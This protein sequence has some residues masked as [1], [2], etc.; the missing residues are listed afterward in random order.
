MWRMDWPPLFPLTVMMEMVAMLTSNGHALWKCLPLLDPAGQSGEN[1]HAATHLRPNW[2]RKSEWSACW[3]WLFSCSFSAGCRCTV[4]TPGGLSM[5]SLPNK[6]CLGHPLLLSICCATPLPVSTQLFTASWTHAS[7]KLCLPH[8]HAV[9]H[10]AIAVV[11]VGYRTKKKMLW[12]RERL[13]LSSHIP[14]SAPWG[15]AKAFKLLWQHII[16]LEAKSVRSVA[17]S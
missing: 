16:C 7:A 3:W 14:P 9:A 8:S 11:G 17:V 1:S 6:P 5:I 13:Y 15:P 10:L 2:R 4:P 12:L